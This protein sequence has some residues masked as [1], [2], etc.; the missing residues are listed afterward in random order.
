MSAL[1]ERMTILQMIEDGKVTAAEGLRLLNA[2]SG[3]GEPPASAAT[4]EGA[5][6]PTG[7]D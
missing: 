2:L 4:V 6:S 3:K 1:D 7:A 5:A